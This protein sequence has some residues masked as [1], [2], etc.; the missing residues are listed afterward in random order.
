MKSEKLFAGLLAIIM[1]FAI[2]VTSYAE[3]MYVKKFYDRETG[4]L[5]YVGKI[6]D[7]DTDAGIEINGTKY[8]VNT[9]TEPRKL[10]IAKAMDGNFAIGLKNPE[11]IEKEYEIKP[12]AKNADGDI[13]YYGE[14]LSYDKDA[15]GDDVVLT[16]VSTEKG[17]LTPAFTSDVTNYYIG[18]SEDI[19]PELN[20]EVAE[21]FTA[22]ITKQAEKAGD[23]TE[24]TVSDNGKTRIYSFTYSVVK[25]V[26]GKTTVKSTDSY[27]IK[28]DTRT[29]KVLYS[30]NFAYAAH[31]DR[32]TYW[33]E[34]LTSNKSNGTYDMAIYS[35]DLSDSTV[36][37]FGK[38]TVDLA[39]ASNA[40]AGQEY[41]LS[42]FA[43][44]N[45]DLTRDSLKP[46]DE[47]SAP[48]AKT[49]AE[50]V[51][52]SNMKIGKIVSSTVVK[53][54]DLIA[55]GAGKLVSIDVSDYV[56]NELLS[57]RKEF[58]I[59]VTI[60]GL[61][62]LSSAT[63]ELLRFYHAKSTNSRAKSLLNCES[64]GTTANLASACITEEAK[65]NG[66]IFLPSF[67]K[68]VKVYYIGVPAGKVIPEIDFVAEKGTIA[69]VVS[70]ASKVG[71]ET[72]ISVTSEGGLATDTYRFIY[73][74]ITTTS[75]T[76]I[77][78]VQS[79]NVYT[80][81]KAWETANYDRLAYN[82]SV[83]HT[84]NISSIMRF[85]IPE[86]SSKYDEF[87]I[88]LLS[89]STI[90]GNNNE[91]T[92]LTV[93]FTE[94]DW[95]G[96][97]E[98]AAAGTMLS[99]YTVGNS[100]GTATL[101]PKTQNTNGSWATNESNIYCD[102]TDYVRGEIAKG[103]TYFNIYARINGASNYSK[104]VYTS[105]YQPTFRESVTYGPAVVRNYDKGLATAAIDSDKGIL[106]P[107]FSN[108]VYDYEIVLPEADAELPE[109]AY[110]LKN[111]ADSKVEVKYAE[112]VGEATVIS[113][114][115][116]GKTINY[117]FNYKNPYQ[118][119]S[120]TAAFTALADDSATVK[121][122]SVNGTYD[123]DRDYIQ[124]VKNYNEETPATRYA[125]IKLDLRKYNVSP[126]GKYELTLYE[127]TTSSPV[128]GATVTVKGAY[129]PDNWTYTNPAPDGYVVATYARTLGASGS[130]IE[131]AGAQTFTYAGAGGTAHTVDIT[132][133][134]KNSLL[135]GKKVVTLV[136]DF[137]LSTITGATN[138][139]QLIV[140]FYNHLSVNAS[141][142]DRYKPKFT[143]YPA[144]EAE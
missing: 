61:K 141:S 12:Y 142:A 101:T 121:S 103:K 22:E 75:K 14:V 108:N 133:I 114:T 68:A 35:F 70:K 139:Q 44:E 30:N 72:V 124:I 48:D 86:N 19:I 53:G 143:Y 64:L 37:N 27:I 47:T 54:D 63:G 136:L 43:V 18:L 10:E 76:T 34:E 117:T 80:A 67:D 51:A 102:V 120:T 74:N 13:V 134:V 42:A 77:K 28:A 106:Y 29:N 140:N 85:D 79:Q 36:D 109:I 73:E 132:E 4:I 104:T 83:T 97:W 90:S 5:Y 41:T 9:E 65:A 21:G 60:T 84:N 112:S 52:E 45:N 31:N 46:L 126:F 135:K 33:K 113:V 98:R 15:A 82:G 130:S 127:R 40:V 128:A 17:V 71:E 58:S 116:Y 131:E 119:P 89:N 110:T 137:D 81:G 94:L 38:F 96:T 99:G 3:V 2:S 66:N 95:N 118:S 11:K 122:T 129:V 92:E 93:E 138:N 50:I 56:R 125:I 59:G 69:E 55:G 115:T 57:G 91:A 87:C 20:Y 100:I 32:I 16:S 8:S 105:V 62:T 7:T 107:S 39:Y 111:T 26:E 144:V 1:I 123:A 24:I 6:A 78:A 23:T 49:P 88:Y 25:T